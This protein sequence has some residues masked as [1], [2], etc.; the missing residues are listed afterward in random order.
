VQS[1]L[2]W[3]YPLTRSVTLAW[4]IRG[5]LLW[6]PQASF[7]SGSVSF[8]PPDQ[9]F[10]VGGPNDVR[11]FDRNELGPVVYT[12]PASVFDSAGAIPADSL[13]QV[14][15]YPSGG[16][17]FA[18]GNVEVRIPSPIWPSRV[19]FAFFVD[20]GT[21]LER[22]K[23]ALT[24][25]RILVTPGAGIRIATPLGPAR[26]DVGYNPYARAEGP[27]Y[28]IETNGDLTL[29]RDAFSVP[30]GSRYTVHITVG[31]AF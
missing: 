24:P 12:A 15:S 21:L 2:A 18:V 23:V 16:N 7:D 26:V 10:Y 20:A 13:G 30:R 19:R 4:R 3:Y 25:A 22:G 31:Q 1:D 27:L 11:G 6:S 9:R 17:T 14:R 8:V 5:G 29:V 28:R